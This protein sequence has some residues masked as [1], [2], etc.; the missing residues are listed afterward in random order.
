MT[1]Q[2]LVTIILFSLREESLHVLLPASAGTAGLPTTAL[3][4]AESLEQAAN[5][6]IAGLIDPRAS[7]LEQLYTYGEAGEDLRVAYF[8]LVPGEAR[9]TSGCEVRW[10]L[11]ANGMGLGAGESDILAYAQRRL[12]FK[13]VS[14]A[15]GSHLLPGEFTLSELQHAY[16]LILG[17][18]LDKRNFRRRMLQSGMI[19]GTAHQRAGDGR[20]ARLY[21]YRA[22]EVAEVKTRR[23][24]P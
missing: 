16:E 7:H 6:L 13:L 24:F 8:A 4:P 12:R 14:S 21:R 20:P 22:E 17:E 10:A 9:L 11:L 18:V 1:R 19:E 15:L 23:L 5:R 3:Q 2:I